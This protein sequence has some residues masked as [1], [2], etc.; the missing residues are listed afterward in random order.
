MTAL[1]Q[2]MYRPT[3]TRGACYTLLGAAGSA[4]TA[5]AI[6][7]VLMY[8]VPTRHRGLVRLATTTTIATLCIAGRMLG[9]V[10]STI[11]L[12]LERNDLDTSRSK[13]RYLVGRDTDILDAEGIARAV[14]ESVAENTVDAV[15]AAA[16]W[17]AIGGPIGVAAYRA[18]NTLDAMVGHH[19]ERYE[20][21]GW[22]SARLDDVMNW[23]PARIT[24]ALVMIVRVHATREVVAVVTSDARAHPSPNSGVA[25]GAFAA[26]IG[27]Q[28]GGINVYQDRVEDRG[29]LGNGRKPDAQGIRDAISLLR[30]VTWAAAG[31]LALAAAVTTRIDA[32]TTRSS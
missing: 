10:S 18:V 9:D 27:V 26:A 8:L 16:F 14:T 20:H 7:G 30:D 4:G 13:I 19:N 11:A 29:T 31:L 17:T 24:A 21:F 3:R 15:I 5:I 22:A 6:E 32:R 12:P 1:E 28:L 23:I 25:E 2:R